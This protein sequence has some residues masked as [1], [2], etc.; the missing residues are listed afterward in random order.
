MV[1]P[2]NIKTEIRVVLFVVVAV[3]C[4]EGIL[5]IYQDR[6][7]GDIAHLDEVANIVARVAQGDGTSVLFWGNSLLAEGVD[8]PTL[9]RRLGGELDGPVSMGMVRPDG[10][11]PLEW[12][13]LLRK[14]VLNPGQIPDILVLAFGPGHLRD[15]PPEGSISRLAAH[16]V[17]SADIPQLF[18]KDLLT[19]ETR[20]SFLMAR[21]SVVYASRDRIRAR[22]LAELVPRYREGARLIR[23]E[24]P[25]RTGQ[26]GAEAGFRQLNE[27]L[28]ELAAADV[29]IV[30]LPMPAPN[31]WDLEPG[32]L[33]A[34]QSVNA[35]I[36]DVRRRVTLAPDR[37]P[38]NQHLDRRG[39][40][41]FTLGLQ[42]VLERVVASASSRP[43]EPTSIGRPQ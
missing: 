6:L 32:E 8:L 29:R 31:D 35:T 5:H 7:S 11:T 14:V 4:L 1:G 42:P 28:R 10:T 38:D 36:L 13:F 26:S 37:F 23:P 25:E 9:E 19:L 20:A 27:L 15:R 24:G 30:A 3:L 43:N 22:V 40:D 17:D 33:A 2:S 12:R 39:R 34:L 21:V 16:H 41:T 18:A